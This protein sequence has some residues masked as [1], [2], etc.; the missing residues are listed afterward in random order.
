MWLVKLVGAETLLTC[1]SEETGRISI[2]TPAALTEVF[3]VFA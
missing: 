2:R 1:I 3:C